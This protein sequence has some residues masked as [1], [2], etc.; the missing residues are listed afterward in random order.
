M[1]YL[2]RRGLY[3]IAFLFCGD[4]RSKWAVIHSSCT[5]LVRCQQALAVPMYTKSGAAS[6]KICLYTTF[7]FFIARSVQ[8]AVNIVNLISVHF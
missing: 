5:N 6:D 4:L 2:W 3:D 1:E 7:H 8:T